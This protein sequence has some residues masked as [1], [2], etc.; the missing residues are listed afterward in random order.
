MPNAIQ[1]NMQSEVRSD[2][3]NPAAAKPRVE[4]ARFPVLGVKV[5]AVQIPDAIAVLQSWIAD[6][7]G[8]HY[9]A[10]TGMHGISESV[11][12]PKFRAALD[13]ASLVVC[14]G[15]P[16]VWLGRLRG[17]DLA[18]RVYGPELMETFCQ[19]TGAQYRHFF[20]GGAEGVPEGL[21]K[22]LQ[23]RHGIQVAGCYSPPFRPLTP[24]EDKAVVAMIEDAHPDVLWIGL[25][26]PKQERWMYEHRDK[27]TVPAVLGVGAAFDLNTGR[28]NQAPRW[29]REN[30]FEWLFRLWTEPKRLWRRYLVNGPVFV[31]NV[32][33]ELMN[34]RKFD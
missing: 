5:D 27:L 29:M 19:T 11:S 1:D 25:S 28:L 23:S 10:V 26:T 21:A 8:Y 13:A 22:A 4:P 31:W 7:E 2:M 6:R 18:R 20:Y 32:G 24:E 30:G 33:L 14:D 12:D 3:P 9:V 15:M 34:V 17:H 16:L